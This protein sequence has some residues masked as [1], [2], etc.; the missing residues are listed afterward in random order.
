MY[1]WFSIYESIFVALISLCMSRSN[2]PVVT[3][4]MLLH[5]GKY[6]EGNTWRK[7]TLREMYFPVRFD[8][9]P[10]TRV[11]I[12]D[13]Q[14]ERCT[15]WPFEDMDSPYTQTYLLLHSYAEGICHFSTSTQHPGTSLDVINFTR[16]SPALV[17]QA[18]NI[19]TKRP[20]YE[21]TPKIS[22]YMLQ[23]RVICLVAWP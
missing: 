21:A 11:C 15:D 12:Y 1:T 2:A 5:K 14:P 23:C 20:G 10:G 7:Y 6:T 16:N 22:P 17:L 13:V 19:G 4:N 18:T 9:C 3:V 8:T